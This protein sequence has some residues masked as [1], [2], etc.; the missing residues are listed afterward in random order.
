MARISSPSGRTDTP[1]V[2]TSVAVLASMRTC[3][4]VVG[5]EGAGGAAG[6]VGAGGAA[7]APAAETASGDAALTLTIEVDAIMASSTAPVARK[8]WRGLALKDFSNPRSSRSRS[9]RGVRLLV[10]AIAT[11]A[12]GHAPGV[13]N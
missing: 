11:A 6:T 4:R 12:T 5:A 9:M 10:R 2:E 3:G 1:P 7:G 13:A 8:A